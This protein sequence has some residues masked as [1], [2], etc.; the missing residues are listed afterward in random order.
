V[1]IFAAPRSPVLAARSACWSAQIEKFVA[2]DAE[3]RRGGLHRDRVWTIVV[4]SSSPES[5]SHREVG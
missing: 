4:K 5:S 2:A 1:V 3:D